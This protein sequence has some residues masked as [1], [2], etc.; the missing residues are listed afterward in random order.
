MPIP[1]TRYELKKKKHPK[2][3]FVIVKYCQYT[4]LV[5]FEKFFYFIH[6]FSL[7]LGVNQFNHDK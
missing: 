6:A 2:N 4:F 1:T 5:H 3:T 7:F